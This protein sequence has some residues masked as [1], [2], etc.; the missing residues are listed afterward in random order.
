V[1]PGHIT[2]WAASAV[3]SGLPGDDSLWA[4]DFARYGTRLKGAAVGA[5]ATKAR[6][7]GGHVFPVVGR[8]NGGR[9]VGRGGN[10]SDMVCDEVFDPS[11]ITAFT[12]PRDYPAPVQVGF[13]SLP[14]ITPAPKTK[15]GLALPPPTQL[16]FPA[17]GV[18]PAPKA[19]KE[20]IT[21]GVPAGGA[22]GGIGFW[23][24]V[25]VIRGRRPAWRSS[26]QARLAAP[27]THSTADTRRAMRRRPPA[28]FPSQLNPR[29]RSCCRSSS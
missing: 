24:W 11:V 21:K 1:W 10:Q 13:A 29:S 5:N 28:S 26:A 22:A 6:D 4:L 14:T 15:R 17:K 25:A 16:E 3:A 19:A 18:V 12:W 27:S 8:T 20:I 2:T 23:D 9:L 7:G